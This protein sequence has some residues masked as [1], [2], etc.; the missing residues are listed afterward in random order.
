MC[1]NCKDGV[2]KG[3]CTLHMVAKILVI[4]GGVNW[5]LVGLG[6]LMSYSISS[7]NVVHIIFGSMPALEGIIY[8]L[9]GVAAVMMIFRGKCK[10]CCG[11]EAPIVSGATETKM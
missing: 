7:W 2:C 4:V 3:D 1:G 5:G 8:V 11:V 6:M 9:V 10:K